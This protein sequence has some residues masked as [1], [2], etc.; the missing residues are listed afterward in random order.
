MLLYCLLAAA[1]AVH[2]AL[3]ISGTTL[4]QPEWL[5]HGGLD[6]QALHVLQGTAAAAA[7]EG[8]SI[9][10]LQALG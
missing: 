10:A 4:V 1:P 5:A 8:V 3:H 9:T 7:A 6:V 2:A